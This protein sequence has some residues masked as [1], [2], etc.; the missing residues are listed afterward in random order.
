M[1]HREKEA[2]VPYLTKTLQSAKG[3]FVAVSDYV[4]ALPESVSKWIP[5]HLVSLGTDGFGRSDG[6]RHLRNFFEID[7]RYIV[8]AV[9]HNFVRRGE[10]DVKIMQKAMKEM[11]IDPNKANPVIS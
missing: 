3:D 8:I 2:R 4:K 5:G 7:E 9:L 10:L 6:R 1:Y 11:K